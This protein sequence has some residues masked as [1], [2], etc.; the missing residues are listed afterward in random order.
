MQ[1]LFLWQAP[2][3]VHPS[4]VVA[5]AALQMAAMGQQL[6]QQPQRQQERV[7]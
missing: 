7:R 3:Q 1:G 6:S 5:T 4:P 2:R